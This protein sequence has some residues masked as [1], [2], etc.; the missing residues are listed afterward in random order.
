MVV[1]LGAGHGQ[2]EKGGGRGVG[3]IHDL[4]DPELLLVDS[5]LGV[6]ERVAV[7]PG[8]HALFRSGIRQQIPGHLLDDESIVGE[9][10]IDG[11]DD[12]L[13]VTPGVGAGTILLES[14]AVGVASQVQPVTRPA[15]PE[16]R[17]GEQLPDQTL[18][19]VGKRAVHERLHLGG[20]GR[21]SQQVQVQPAD[22]S[23]P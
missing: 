14:V 17:R 13:T 12:P 8:R 10:P 15:L 19:G 22:Q 21:E 20:S 9:V 6:R 3:P 23:L 16:M 2:T 7:K 1:A 18:V 5:P 4:F 11:L